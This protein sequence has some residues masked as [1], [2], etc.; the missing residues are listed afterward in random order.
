MAAPLAPPAIA[1]RIAPTT[2]PPPIFLALELVGA[3]PNR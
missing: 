1:P 2:V 3:A